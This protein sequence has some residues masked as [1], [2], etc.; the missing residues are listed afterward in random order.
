ML[1]PLLL[2]ISERYVIDWLIDTAS[3]SQLYLFTDTKRAQVSY[4]SYLVLWCKIFTD[5]FT[6]YLQVL[7]DNGWK[8]LLHCMYNFYYHKATILTAVFKGIKESIHH[9]YNWMVKEK[10]AEIII[11]FYKKL[12]FHQY[13]LVVS[14][15]CMCALQWNAWM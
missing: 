13:N 8:I 9:L 15:F 3:T 1:S 10:M 2:T 4:I 11:L 5:F 14:L 6:Y 12:N 7:S